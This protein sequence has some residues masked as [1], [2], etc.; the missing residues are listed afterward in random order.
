MQVL[1]RLPLKLSCLLVSDNALVCGQD[2]NTKSAEN[3]RK[4]VLASVHTKTRLGDSLDAGDDLLVLI[5]TVLQGDVHS[6]YSAILGR[7]HIL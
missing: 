1:L 7:D 6:L 4:V 5:C 3:L 2:R